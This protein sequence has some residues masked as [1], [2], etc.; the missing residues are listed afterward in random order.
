MSSSPPYKQSLE[1]LA[2]RAG[3]LRAAGGEVYTFERDVLPYNSKESLLNPE[4]VAVADAAYDWWGVL[5]QPSA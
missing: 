2:A 4:F 5:P 3:M 1:Q